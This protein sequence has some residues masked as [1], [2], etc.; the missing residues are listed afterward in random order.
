MPRLF[1]AIILIALI[2]LAVIIAITQL[3]RA[4]N[5]PSGDSP[6]ATGDTMQKVAYFLLLGLMAYVAF[7]GG[8]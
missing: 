7:A 1:L 4:L 5:P 3:A 8:A 6:V 2:V